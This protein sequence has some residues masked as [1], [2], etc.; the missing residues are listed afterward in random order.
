MVLGDSAF[1]LISFFF[2][3]EVHDTASSRKSLKDERE[4]KYA[5]EIKTGWPGLEWTSHSMPV[6]FLLP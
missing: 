1:N 3:A 5:L 6:S 4:E 2:F